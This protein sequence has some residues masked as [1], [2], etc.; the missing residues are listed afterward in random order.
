M[1]SSKKKASPKA[2]TRDVDVLARQLDRLEAMVTT[3]LQEHGRLR[4]ALEET[5]QRADAA[6]FQRIQ[7]LEDARAADE[8]AKVEALERIDSFIAKTEERLQ[9]LERCMGDVAM[10]RGLADREILGKSH[11]LER[12]LAPPA[13]ARDPKHVASETAVDEAVKVALEQTRTAP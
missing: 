11:E 7:K 2:P 6:A 8:K 1:S 9:E 4:R 3:S 12:R 13:S 10:V 5:V